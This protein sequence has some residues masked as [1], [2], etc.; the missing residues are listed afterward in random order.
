MLRPRPTAEPRCWVMG[1]EGASFAPSGNGVRSPRVG[2]VDDGAGSVPGQN[3][4]ER[5]GRCEKEKRTPAWR[6]EARSKRGRRRSRTNRGF[7]FEY[8]DCSRVVDLPRPLQRKT[9]RNETLH[10]TGRGRVIA[11]RWPR[12]TPMGGRP[13]RHG[14]LET[15]RFRRTV[16]PWGPRDDGCGLYRAFAPNTSDAGKRCRVSSMTSKCSRVTFAG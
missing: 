16:F 10:P 12:P 9:V 3:E 14:P 7:K 6:G 2:A 5:G 15:P 4:V 13:Q 1:R 11:S 8:L